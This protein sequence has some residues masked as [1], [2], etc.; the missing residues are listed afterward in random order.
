DCGGADQVS[1]CPEC[2]VLIGG[3]NHQTLAVNERN[4]EYESM[5]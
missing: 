5:E 3:S 2:G 1:I 4:M